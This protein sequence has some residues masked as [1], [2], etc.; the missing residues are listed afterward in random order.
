MGKTRK[1]SGKVY[2]LV[3]TT[4]NKVDANRKARTIRGDEYGSLARVTS[5][6]VK[7]EKVTY[8]MVWMRKGS[9]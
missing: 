4:Q 3:K 7:G 8:H 2:T 5:G 6:K 1:F 9:R